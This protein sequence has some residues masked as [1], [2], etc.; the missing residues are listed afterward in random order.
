[1]TCGVFFVDGQPVHSFARRQGVQSTSSAE[2]ELYGASSVVFDG[3]LLRHFLEWVGYKVNYV[4]WV[5]SSSAKSII[6]R[7]GVGKIK[8][9]DVR[10]LWLQAEREHNHLVVKVAGEQNPAI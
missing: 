10:S 6:Q 3:R 5:D 1:M 9:L 4:L 8:H 2:A 7:E